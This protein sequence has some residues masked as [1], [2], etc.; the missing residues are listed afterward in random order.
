MIRLDSIA[1]EF[2]EARPLSE[3][4]SVHTAV[5]EHSF[6]TKGGHLLTVLRVTGVD[7]ECLDHPQLDHVARRFEA[8]LRSLPGNFR[9]YQLM[10]KRDH[11]PL[12]HQDYAD[13]T[14][15]RIIENRI[16]YLAS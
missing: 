5:D 9:L 7:H 13:A 4:I 12:P 11:A 2:R 6:I 1:Q 16:D 15:R 10:L 3:L 14:I 8:A